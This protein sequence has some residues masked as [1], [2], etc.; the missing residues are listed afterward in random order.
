MNPA[1]NSTVFIPKH[2]AKPPHI[3]LITEPV[4]SLVS[5]ERVD[6]RE[7]FWRRILLN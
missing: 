5:Q 3:Q 7:D 4:L 2:R 6:A 1:F